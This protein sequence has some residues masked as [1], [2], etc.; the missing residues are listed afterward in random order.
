MIQ[1]IA[2][3][4][5]LDDE[6]VHSRAFGEGQC[7]THQTPEALAQGVVEA[8]D[9]ICR[10]SFGVAGT[11]RAFFQPGGATCQ[12]SGSAPRRLLRSA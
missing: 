8:L 4:E 1:I 3:Q 12:R 10:A 6:F 11:F 5:E 2:M 9:V 7:F